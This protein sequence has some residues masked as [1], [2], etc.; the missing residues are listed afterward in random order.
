HTIHIHQSACCVYE[1]LS[2]QE[3]VD[4]YSE[5]NAILGWT[6][7]KIG[8]FLSSKLLTG[9]VKSNG[10]GCLITRRSFLLLVNYAIG[11]CERRTFLL[12]QINTQSQ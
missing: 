10:R 12:R 11:T 4:E 2:P 9:I 8:V 6:P 5:L 1:L 3:I 7:T